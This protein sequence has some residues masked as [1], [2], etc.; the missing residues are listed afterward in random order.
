M[1]I[2][3]ERIVQGVSYQVR[4]AGQSRRLYVGGVLHTSYNPGRAWTGSA[5]DLLTL[6]ALTLPKQRPFRALVLGLGGGAVVQLLRR[7]QPPASTVAVDLSA[8]MVDAA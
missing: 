3:F 1:A 7:H 6:P 2:L 8:A 5:W 4:S